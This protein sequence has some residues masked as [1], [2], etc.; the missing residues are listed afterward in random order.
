M[1]KAVGIGAGGHAKVVIEI[2]KL[3]QVCEVVGL[4]D[5]DEQKRGREIG[6]VPVIGDD[7]LLETLYNQGIRHAFVG[8][9]SVGDSTARRRLFDNAQKIGYSI[10]AAIHP[11]AVISESARLGVGPTVMAGCVVNADTQ[12]GDNVILNTGAIVDHDCTIG[13][14]V[15]IAPRACLSGGVKVG[16]GAHVGAGA[17]VRQ[18]ISIG[19]DAI[20]G[21]G[22]VVVKDVPD[23]VTVIGVPARIYEGETI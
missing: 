4:L 19:A 3:S 10:V 13:N 21:V 16:E 6:G 14:H 5:S 1:V 18:E 12:I 15:H 22:S 20:I 11:H 7:T 23:K 8:L 2:L 9:G 17:F